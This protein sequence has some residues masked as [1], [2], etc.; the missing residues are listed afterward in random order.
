VL[1]G[2]LCICNDQSTSISLKN[3]LVRRE[4]IAV[5]TAIRGG[6]FEPFAS[7]GEDRRRK[8]DEIGQFPQ[9]LGSGGQEELVLG[10]ARPAQAQSIEP[11]GRSG[12]AIDGRWRL[13]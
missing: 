2:Y 12:M 10:S 11:G 3:P 8:G 4:R 6:R 1:K 13:F 9:I 7:C 5:A